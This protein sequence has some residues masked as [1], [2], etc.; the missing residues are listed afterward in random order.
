MDILKINY[1]SEADVTLFDIR[2]SESEVIIYA[3]CL[4]YVLSHLSDEQ[5]YEKTECSNQKELS[6]YLEDLKTLI[7]SMEHKSYLPD[8]YKDL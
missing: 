2:L 6:H 8:R 7:K 1:I 5:I 3:D 4:N